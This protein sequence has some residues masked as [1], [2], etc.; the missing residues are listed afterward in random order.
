[1]FSASGSPSGATKV[2]C[3]VTRSGDIVR[4]NAD[5]LKF[6]YR[7]SHL[8]EGWVI[9]QA[10]F[11]APDGDPDALKAKMDDQLAKRDATQPTK[12]RTAGSTFRNPAGYSSTGR[13]DDAHDLKAWKLIDDAGLRGQRLGGA[14]MSEKHPNFLTNA[15]HAT[16]A[17]LEQLGEL[18]R[19]RVFQ[20]AGIELKWEVIRVGEPLADKE[21]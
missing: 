2:A 12:D 6:G 10:T 1:A 5:D 16:A 17:D 14:Q 21:E 15:D 9:T 18:V 7:E 20:S 8:A 4:L 19:K 13:P 3:V 11:V